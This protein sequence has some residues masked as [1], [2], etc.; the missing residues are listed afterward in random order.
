MI[1][2]GVKIGNGAVVA[3]GTVVTKDV[4]P[5]AIVGG[6]PQKIIK[7]RFEPDQI[8]KLLAI[9]WWNWSYSELKNQRPWF[10]KDIATFVN[11]FYKNAEDQSSA[12]PL[13]IERKGTAFLFLPDFFEPYSVWE[14]VLA[15]YRSAFT[16]DK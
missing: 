9:R 12:K 13:S 11:Q 8:E 14:R 2:S 4:P 3:A 6:S 7:Y 15:E 1:M 16:A 10:R 5:Y